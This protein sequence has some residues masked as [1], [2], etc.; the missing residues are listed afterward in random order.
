M[1][2][3]IFGL[4]RVIEPKAAV[5]VTA[6]KV[7]NDIKISPYECRVSLELIHLERDCFQQFC[8]EC[9]FDEA[10]IIAKITITANNSTKVKPLLLIITS[11]PI[12]P[13]K[14][15]SFSYI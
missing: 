2:N 11:L 7:N 14:I 8:S 13:N 9:G 3:D 4:S 6:W 5:P 12:L 10:K 15:I 1:T